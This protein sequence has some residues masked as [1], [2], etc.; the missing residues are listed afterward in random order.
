MITSFL[1][2]KIIKRKDKAD[3][4]FSNYSDRKFSGNISFGICFGCSVLLVTIDIKDFE[5]RQQRLL[6]LDW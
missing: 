1:R 2:E 4:E 5:S 6:Q 3:I